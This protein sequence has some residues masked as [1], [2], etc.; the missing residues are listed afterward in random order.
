MRNFVLLLVLISGFLSGYLI[1]DY[2]GR[3]A[4]ESLKKAV[5]TGKT[6]DSERE[7]TIT[8]LRKELEGIN[9]KHLRE[10]ET[11]RKNSAAKA[12]EW[13]REKDSLGDKIK[14]T[15]AK[16]NDFDTQL[17]SL[18]AK[19]D[20]ASAAEKA[21]IDLEISRLRKERDDLRREV[22]GNACLQTVVPHSVSETLNEESI[23]GR[24]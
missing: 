3:I 15:T 10:L 9:D 13:R 16:L 12:A 19:R 14:L 22:E 20:G 17:K 23:A 8:Q 24:K 11:V 4:R 5:D 1:G 6:L 21:G 2:R 18:A 7:A